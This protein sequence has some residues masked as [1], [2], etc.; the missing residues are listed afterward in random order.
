MA[1][2]SDYDFEGY[3]KLPEHVIRAAAAEYITRFLMPQIEG[4]MAM[5]I[6]AMSKDCDIEANEA[7]SAIIERLQ[8]MTSRLK[9]GQYTVNHAAILFR[10]WGLFDERQGKGLFEINQ[11]AKDWLIEETPGQDKPQADDKP[12]PSAQQDKPQYWQVWQPDDS[13]NEASS[14]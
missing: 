7:E 10:L 13:D 12:A 11:Q 9:P 8:T 14:N 5:A 6:E 2:I 1:E 3:G 4:F